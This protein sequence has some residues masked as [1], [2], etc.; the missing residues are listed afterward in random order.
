MTFGEIGLELGAEAL[1]AQARAYGFTAEAGED[2]IPFD[3][4]WVSGVFPD[5]AT[6]E[7]REPA[8]AI[9]AIGQQDVA[10]NVLHMALVAASIGNGGVMMEPNLVTEVRDPSGQ[11]MAE[12]GP[13]VFSEPLSPQNAAALTQMMVSV[14]EGGH[15]NRRADPR[16]LD[17]GQDGYCPARRGRGPSRVV[18]VVRPGRSPRGRRRG[19]GARRG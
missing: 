15:R 14:V 5:A 7:Q 1:A 3:I 12:F 13:E 18:R 17:R 11:V 9:S 16:C 10:T 19:H 8:V 4:P 6:F 2:V